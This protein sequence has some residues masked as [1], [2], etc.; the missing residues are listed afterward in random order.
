MYRWCYK[1]KIGVISGHPIENLIDNSERITI[2]TRY[3]VIP[4]YISEQKGHKVFFINR[5]GDPAR[6]PPHKINYLGNI[7]AFHLSHIDN[8]FSIG[9]VG[10][11]NLDIKPGDF[12]IPHDFFDATK[13][14]ISTFYDDKRFHVDMS[15]PF[16]PALRTLLEENTGGLKETIHMRGVY[17]A[18]EGPRL[19][20]A[21]EI[22]FY[23][24]T[25][26]IVG[27]TVVPEVR[28]ARER[29]ICYVSLCIVC[30][31]AARLQGSLP[32]EDISKVFHSKEKSVEMILKNA[33]QNIENKKK[34]SCRAKMEKAML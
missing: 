15:D 17:L 14:R 19:E 29:G 21:S 10:S 30:N 25:A 16:C 6:L 27:M 7:E 13:N 1:L 20:T 11:M 23:S 4:V 12:V 5:H 34:C 3:G 22:K 33:I 28:L 8:I 32:A 2:E 9:T 24:S 18:T 26:D 31:M